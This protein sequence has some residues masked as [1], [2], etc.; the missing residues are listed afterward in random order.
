M[1]WHAA[2]SLFMTAWLATGLL[3]IGQELPMFGQL[4]KLDKR[5][6]LCAQGTNGTS[7]YVC[8]WV[9]LTNS[10]SGDMLSFAAQKIGTND[11]PKV[12]RVPWSDAAADMFPGGYPAWDKPLDQSL[13]VHW[14]RNEVVEVNT[15][16]RATGKNIKQEALEYTLVFEDKSGTN[17]LAHGYALALGELRVFVQ[18]TSTKA[19][20]PDTAHEIA[21]GL[22]W[23]H[24]K[25][26][27]APNPQGK[28]HKQLA[29]PESKK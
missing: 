15:V 23:M 4:P 3:A 7:F 25:Q 19:I 5:W 17:R 10:Q 6:T 2:E 16:D 11:F 21:S 24:C 20:T 8:S 18:H 9:V 26:A 28:V 22:I 14:I 12:N 27:A 29:K 1:K 13:R